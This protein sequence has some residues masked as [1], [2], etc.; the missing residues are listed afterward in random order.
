MWFCGYVCGLLLVVLVLVS[1]PVFVLVLVLL[2]VV[3]VVVVVVVECCL[4]LVLSP[5]RFW[6]VGT[7]PSS[8]P[9]WW[10][11]SQWPCHA[12]LA[13]WKDIESDGSFF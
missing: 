1:V 13:A 2:V 3:V 5:S 11:P 4:I 8:W 6:V 9:P 12:Q 10:L 7:A